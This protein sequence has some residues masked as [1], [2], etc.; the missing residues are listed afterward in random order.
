MRVKNASSRILIGFIVC[1]T[2][3]SLGQSCGGPAPTPSPS[4]GD[5]NN[6]PPRLTACGLV[7]NSCEVPTGSHPDSVAL[8]DFDNDGDLDAAVANFGGDSVSVLTNNGSGKLTLVR[9]LPAG[10]TPHSILTADFNRDGKRDIAVGSVGAIAGPGATVFL[11]QGLVNFSTGIAYPTGNV[12]TMLAAGDLDLSGSID[13]I[14]ANYYS[15]SLSLLPGAGNGIFGGAVNVQVAAG[16]SAVVA[17]DLDNDGDIDLAATSEDTSNVSVLRNTGG[18]V[19]LT[20]IYFGV[21]FRPVHIAAAELDNDGDL[22]LIVANQGALADTADTVSILL[23]NGNATF[24]LQRVISVGANPDFVLA[25]DFNGDSRPDLAVA[26][27]GSGLDDSGVAILINNG[28]ANF[29]APV[30]FAAG[31][32]PTALAA[33]DLDG[34]NDLDL[35]VTDFAGNQL[36]LL[37]NDGKGFFSR[38]E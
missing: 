28:G 20:P 18:A 14:T 3:L 23:N 33:G 16:P 19:F 36:V 30:L 35:A 1:S 26:N 5:G 29:G 24:A 11:N 17:A 38:D 22:D 37:G 27:L 4:P 32:S 7:G 13:L 25:A 6:T 2:A 8:A 34:D 12:G 9:T 31:D 15:N 21:G 10:D